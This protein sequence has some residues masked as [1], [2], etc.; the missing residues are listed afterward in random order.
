MVAV[1]FKLNAAYNHNVRNPRV[2]QTLV[3]KSLF[4]NVPLEETI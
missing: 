1:V 4:T 2:L 3:I